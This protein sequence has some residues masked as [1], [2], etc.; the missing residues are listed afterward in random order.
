MQWR[1]LPLST[2]RV[3]LACMLIALYLVMPTSF[4]QPEPRT[5]DSLLEIVRDD[6]RAKRVAVTSLRVEIV[7]S[8]SELKCAFP[9]MDE[10]YSKLTPDGNVDTTRI[11]DGIFLDLLYQAEAIRLATDADEKRSAFWR[12]VLRQVEITIQHGMNRRRLLQ[13]R[14]TQQEAT[15]FAESIQHIYDIKLQQY[16]NTMNLRYVNDSTAPLVI[17]PVTFRCRNR[18]FVYI[19]PVLQFRLMQ[20]YPDHFAS[21]EC[22]RNVETFIP[23]GNYVYS[24]TKTQPFNMQSMITITSDSRDIPLRGED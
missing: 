18:S 4:A 2:L 16:A 20:L 15:A 24:F 3:L 11:P 21:R 8:S 7:Q 17:L 5:F 6:I 14:L 23:V 13:R 12:P 10:F 1:T 22:S 19:M 9:Q